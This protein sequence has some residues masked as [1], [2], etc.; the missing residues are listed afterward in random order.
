LAGYVEMPHAQ[1]AF[2][3][4]RHT[5]N[6]QG[7]PFRSEVVYGVSS[8]SALRD[9]PK[10]LLHSVRGH[11]AIENKVHHV[12]DVTFDEDRS[13]VRKGNGPQVMAT[14]RNLA[15]SLLRLAGVSN[16]ARATRY[17]SRRV[18]ETLRLLGV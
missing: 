9:G 6:L 10:A 13:R 8:L 16:I 7:Q 12:R 3:V 17:L 5:T 15:L 14:L 11:W 1:A 4:I 2:R 18:K